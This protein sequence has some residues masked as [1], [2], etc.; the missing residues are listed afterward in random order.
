MNYLRHSWAVCG[1][2]GFVEIL[3]STADEGRLSHCGDDLHP[4]GGFGLHA[5]S[6]VGGE[7]SM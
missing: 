2:I 6:K 4:A 1:R 3:V 5:V 7:I